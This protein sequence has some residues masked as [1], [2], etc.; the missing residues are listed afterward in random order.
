M[1]N[2]TRIASHI[3]DCAQA[4]ADLAESARWYEERRDN[5]NRCW[6]VRDAL[7]NV[8]INAQQ[9]ERF[10]LPIPLYPEVLGHVRLLRADYVYPDGSTT[11]PAYNVR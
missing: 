6:S 7:Y 10:G 11:R 8:Q 2:L 3:T 1:L 9:R 5:R 4:L